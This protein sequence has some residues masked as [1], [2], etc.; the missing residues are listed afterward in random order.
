LSVRTIC[1]HGPESVGKSVLAAQLATH[2]GG[3]LVGEYGRDYCEVHGTDCTMDDLLAIARAQQKRIAAAR[4]RAARWV[5]ADTDALMTAV[6]ADMTHGCRDP[7]FDGLR[8][9]ADLYLLL[10]IDLPFI[11]DG[12]RLY[13][14]ADERARFFALCRHE[15][16]RRGV[17]WALVRGS[18]PARFEAAMAAVDAAFGGGEPPR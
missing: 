8:D 16:E 14:G 17:R 18:G 3:E 12:L 13:G 4:E 9:A 2:F 11:D 15:L 6:W 1:L 5:I 7:W 10:D